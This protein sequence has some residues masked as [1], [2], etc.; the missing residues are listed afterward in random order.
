METALL[1]E[2]LYSILAISGHPNPPQRHIVGIDAVV[3]VKEKLKAV[4]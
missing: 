4:R 2:T 1:A 3:S